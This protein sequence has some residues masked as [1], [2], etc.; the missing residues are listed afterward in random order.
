M[1]INILPK[2]RPRG[3]KFREIILN[4]YA[5][6]ASS[7]LRPTAKD[8]IKHVKKTKRVK[9]SQPTVQRI[10]AE[11]R[12]KQK[13]ETPTG[14]GSDKSTDLIESCVHCSTTSESALAGAEPE[15]EEV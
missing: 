5:E 13:A 6:L 4:A 8:I 14:S 15:T 9:V 2:G 7:G 10:L 1:E 11:E 3:S 12:D